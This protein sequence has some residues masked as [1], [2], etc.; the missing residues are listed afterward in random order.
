VPLPDLSTGIVPL[1]G[2]SSERSPWGFIHRGYVQSWNFTL[3]HKMPLGILTSFGYV[4]SHS[5]HLLADR[6]INTGFPGST[7]ANLPYN[8]AYGRTQAS[9]MWDGYLSSSYNS[10]QVA[11]SRSF[12]KGLM[13]KGAYTWSHAIDYTDDDGWAGVDF[14]YAPMFQRNRAT[15][16]FDVPQN[17]QI[18]WVYE[19]PFGKDKSY[20][21]SGFMSK[22]A[23][24]WQLSGREACYSGTPFSI[25]AP[26]TSLN[27]GGTNTQTADQVLSKVA[28]LGNIGPGAYYYDPA[29]FAPVTAVRFG[30]S[31]RN[32]LRNPGMWN[33]DLSILRA[34]AIKERLNLQFRAEFNN[35]PNT[36]HFTGA[37][38]GN[39]FGNGGGG[40]DNGVTDSTFMQVTSSSGERNIRFGLRLQW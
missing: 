4:A 36:S 12:S 11:V 13:L 32:I 2:D 19:L 15:A 31:G 27:D 9:N 7:L 5:V 20:L 26:D 23:G 3:E 35:L 18:G 6:D 14:N 22:I 10:L 28:F 40:L 29:A 34:F 21:N 37:A 38:T 8:L 1:P 33:T 24:G 16:G 30:N 39:G 17:F 25:T